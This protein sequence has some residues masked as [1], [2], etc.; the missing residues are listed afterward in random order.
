VLAE[1]S[2]PS[3]AGDRVAELHGDSFFGKQEPHRIIYE[4]VSFCNEVIRY[5]VPLHSLHRLMCS[6]ALLFSAR[7]T[8]T[9]EAKAASL[10]RLLRNW[11]KAVFVGRSVATDLAVPIGSD[12]GFVEYLD[13]LTLVEAEENDA[14]DEVL[15]PRMSK[16]PNPVRLPLFAS[17]HRRA[18]GTRFFRGRGLL[19]TEWS[20]GYLRAPKTLESSS[21]LPP[22]PDWELKTDTW[23]AT[24]VVVSYPACSFRNEYSSAWQIVYS[25][26]YC[27]L[28][29]AWVRVLEEDEGCV[30]LDERRHR[31]F[32]VL[33]T[34]KLREAPGGEAA[35]TCLV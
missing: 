11:P 26:Y 28:I 35:R 25:E 30:R 1:P 23:V 13:Q 24:P 6:N 5:Q 15:N 31:H 2:T 18:A 10:C 21:W 9:F 29:A 22:V 8:E 17:G 27:N 12:A 7:G 16:L 20:A 14:V 34:F 3:H 19:P 32:D 4:V 33:D